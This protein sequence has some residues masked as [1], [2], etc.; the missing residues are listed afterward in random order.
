MCKVQAARLD[1]CAHKKVPSNV[2]EG[3]DKCEEVIQI[4]ISLDVPSS[5]DLCPLAS[6]PKGHD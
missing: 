6:S 5:A 2:L 3:R 1:S 4:T